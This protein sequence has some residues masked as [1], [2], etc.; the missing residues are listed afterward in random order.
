MGQATGQTIPLKGEV[1]SIVFTGSDNGFVIAR[2]RAKGEPGLVTVVGTLGEV[3]PGELLELTGTWKEH[4]K[5]GR[6]FQAATCR[7]VLPATINGIKRYLGSGCIKGI[8]P[9][10]A[11]K[12]VKAFGVRVLDILDEDPKQLLQVPGLGKK[13]LA[14][15]TQSWEKQREIRTLMLFLQTYG[16][17]PTFAGKIFKQYGIQSVE[18]LK[19]DPYQLVYEI[20]GIGFTTADAMALKLGFAEDSYERIQAGIMYVLYQ[21]GERGHLFYPADA[22]LE[23]AAHTLGHIQA[24]RLREG[25]DRLEDARR[26]VIEDL[27]EQHVHQAVYPSFFHRMEREIVARLEATASHTVHVDE[28]KLFGVM[29][30][31]EQ[32]AGV[33]LSQEQRDAVLGACQHKIY[34]ITGGP[35]TGKTTIT[36]MVAWSLQSLGLEVKLAAPTGRA[37]KRLAEATGRCASTIHRLLKYDPLGEGGFVFNE[38]KKLKVDAL[39]VDEVSM[40]DCVLCLHLLRALPLTCRIIFVGDVNQLPSVGPG[41]L[42]RDCL[43]SGVVPHK[44]LT[45]IFR[46]AQESMIVVNAHRINQGE[47]PLGATKPIP[48]ADFFWVENNDPLRIQQIILKTACERIPEVYGL[49]PLRDV[50]VLTPMHKGDVGTIVLNTLLQERLN[51]HGQE[52]VRGQRRYRVG[53]RVLQMRNNYDKDVF[54]G[55]LGWIVAADTTAETLRIDFEDRE[56]EYGF[57][58]LD[59]LSLAYAVSVHKSQGSEY[60]A[61]IMPLV[62][63]HFMLLQRNLIY[64]G[65]T[66]ARKLAVML[67]S[68]K[69]MSIGLANKESSRRFTHLVYRLRE[70]L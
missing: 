27:P 30:N 50:Q 51:P 3:V 19:Q 44:R 22:L 35:G 2:L 29:D 11:D 45:R 20:R 31:Q 67:G 7:Q 63:Q 6:Q 1:V 23:K 70:M 55:D 58:E 38:D 59:E 69:A 64:T 21:Q 62:T 48:Q 33:S 14:K 42:L 5:F 25:L 34:V 16:I 15:I 28:T 41:N 39:I 56:V 54:N 40:L 12:L 18:R 61:V 8:G 43:E 47:F 13:T 57:D 65:L 37:A 24:D 4:P 10:M 17:A 60:P 68:H 46:Q 49:D 36:R 52:I 9:G 32:R 26:I 66:R 53:D